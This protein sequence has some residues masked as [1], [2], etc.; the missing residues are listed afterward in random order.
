MLDTSVLI[1][2]TAVK[3]HELPAE[4][5]IATITLAEL[6]A[7]PLTAADPKTQ[8]ERLERLQWA[9][10]NFEPIPFDAAAAHSYARIYA[11]TI[12]RGRKPRGGRAIDLFIAATALSRRL[13]LYTLNPVDF[14]SVAELMEI[15]AL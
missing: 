9:Q 15:V 14:N 2:I 13:P 4:T 12:T 10:A 3:T 7:G 5:S 8:A 6:T 11:A 1:G